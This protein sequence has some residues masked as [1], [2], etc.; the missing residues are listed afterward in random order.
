MTQPAV[1][2]LLILEQAADLSIGYKQAGPEGCRM[3]INADVFGGGIGIFAST[4]TIPDGTI[5]ARAQVAGFSRMTDIFITPLAGYTGS[6]LVPVSLN[7][8]I[9][10]NLRA[11]VRENA[12]FVRSAGASINA[13]VSLSGAN[14][15][16]G[17]DSVFDSQRFDDGVGITAEG[18]ATR[19]LIGLLRPTI[20]Q[21]IRRAMTVNFSLSGSAG[22]VGGTDSFA[23][24]TLNA[25][26]T[27]SFSSSGPAFFLPA[28][29]TVN[30][31][32]LNIINNRWV[33]PRGVT[34]SVSPVPLPAGLALLLTGLGA[35]GWLRR[36]QD[37]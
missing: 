9:D 33:D 20:N 17:T 32:E 28:G 34:P 13:T 21:D 15:L 2:V 27:L 4:R 1:K 23:S 8:E 30:A 6:F 36:K 35:F 5:S 37:T 14:G 25:I 3:A 26:N 29:L 7:V 10:G 16:G 31:P 12:Q 24:A 22:V 19:T 18:L 11:E